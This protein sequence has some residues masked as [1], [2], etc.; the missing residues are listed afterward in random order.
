MRDFA[1][2]MKVLFADDH[3]LMLDGI[4]RPGRGRRLPDRWRDAE[5]RAGAPLVG[6]TGP[7]LVVLDVR[8]PNMDGLQCLRRSGAGIRR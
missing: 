4:R 8:M 2:V 1:D 7:D 5:R 3:R 6:Q